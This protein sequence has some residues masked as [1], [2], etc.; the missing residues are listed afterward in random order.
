M[1]ERLFFSW[2]NA[3]AVMALVGCGNVTVSIKGYQ[4]FLDSQVISFRKLPEA[5]AAG[6]QEHFRS[7]LSQVEFATGV[8]TLSGK[9]VTIGNRIYFPDQ[10]RF[11][12]RPH[13]VR[14][15]HE[16]E[17]VDQY[18]KLG[19]QFISK[20]SIQS[21]GSTSEMLAKGKP[22]Y[23]SIHDNIELEK[24]AIEK[25]ELVLAQYRSFFCVKK[26]ACASPFKS[27][28]SEASLLSDEN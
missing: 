13:I 21:L 10:V 4:A 2:A 23:K 18:Q 9:V 1:V 26:G 8:D 16:L 7:D 20:Y 24:E 19:K 3:F 6:A 17:H 25:A 11:N 28:F 14:M 12:S 27:T 15:L 22:R 5:F